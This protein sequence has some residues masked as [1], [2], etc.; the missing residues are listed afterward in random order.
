V[1]TLRESQ[2]DASAVG[3]VVRPQSGSALHDTQVHASQPSLW[4]AFAPRSPS[5][6]QDPDS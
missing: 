3:G 6:L 5:H 1:H 4:R 2:A